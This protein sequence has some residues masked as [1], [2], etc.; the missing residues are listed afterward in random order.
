MNRSVALNFCG[1]CWEIC[2]IGRI[3]M[4]LNWREI[5]LL[6]VR[7]HI[8]MWVRTC[9]YMMPI[10]FCATR[11]NDSSRECEKS[12]TAKIKICWICLIPEHFKRFSFSLAFYFLMHDFNVCLSIAMC[13]LAF[14]IFALINWGKA[15]PC[16]QIH[17]V[18]FKLQ[19][20]YKSCNC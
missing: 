9:A 13:L 20:K 17:S 10:N 5:R 2:V 6:C 14:A 1:C 8:C 12:N 18:R 19:L 11:G 4:S 7:A 16:T 15:L 3:C